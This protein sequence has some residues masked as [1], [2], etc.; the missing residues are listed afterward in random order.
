MIILKSNKQRHHVDDI[1]SLE[2]HKNFHEISRIAGRIGSSGSD[3]EFEHE[4]EVGVMKSS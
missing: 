4:A 2:A 1:R 3:K